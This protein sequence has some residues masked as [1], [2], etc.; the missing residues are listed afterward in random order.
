MSRDEHRPPRV[1]IIG[2]GASGA[3]VAIH[4]LHDGRCPLEIAIFDPSGDPG[5]G[6][7]HGRAAPGHLLNVPAGRMGALADDPGD[8]LSW[9]R[10][11]SQIPA[12]DDF[13]PRLTYGAYLRQRLIQARRSAERVKLRVVTDAVRNLRPGADGRYMVDH[14]S[15]DPWE[16]DWV[17]LA[18][19]NAPPAPL[20]GVDTALEADGRYVNDPW[21]PG[22][23]A[24][25]TGRGHVLVVGTGLTM[26]DVAMTLTSEAR[27][28]VRVEAIS[29]HGLLPTGHRITRCPAPPQIATPPATALGLVRLVRAHVAAVEADRGDWRGG[30]DS[31]RSATG[32]LWR[33]L[34]IA[35]RRR[36]LRH[37]V[38]YWEI[39][40]HRM[41]PELARRV[42]AQIDLGNLRITRARLVGAEPSGPRVRALLDPAHAAGPDAARQVTVDAVVNCTGPCGD[43]DRAAS[44]LLRTLRS[45]GLVRPD[46]LHLSLDTDAEG[47]V[48]DSDGRSHERLL[49]MG[50][51]RRGEGWE[52]TAMPEIR[53]QG[54]AA[55][56]AILE[57]AAA[58]APSTVA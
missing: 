9:L 57:W 5:P 14:G 26:I 20:G 41:A 8:F 17:V 47:R 12:W 36:L 4:L 31:L 50:P 24:S 51:L 39:H 32:P 6:L 54:G 49:A 1:A 18:T 46:P 10:T 16:A 33:A 30:I 28:A 34:P 15:G 27:G 43:I 53:Q 7:A 38:R 2:G 29:R 52:T 42:Q 3:V 56:R 19:G 40:R 58:R 44:P 37:A 48:I 22:A 13:L 45:A 23:L 55:A 35:Q 21:A 25:L 11:Q